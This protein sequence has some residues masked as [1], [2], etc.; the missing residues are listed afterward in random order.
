[1]S[2]K[3]YIVIHEQEA[4]S[5]SR[6]TTYVGFKLGKRVANFIRWN[7]DNKEGERDRI[8]KAARRFAKNLAEETGL[9]IVEK[10]WL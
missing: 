9:E 8:T 3:L 5:M 10:L 7:W 4:D 1:M 6:N 2:K